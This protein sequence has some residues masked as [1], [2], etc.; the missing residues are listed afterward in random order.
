MDAE[1]PVAAQNVLIVER[2]QPSV[3]EPSPPPVAQR[4][5]PP[6]FDPQHT[7]DLLEE[8][9]RKEILQW[10]KA[11]LKYLQDMRRK[12][13]RAHRG[14][15]KPLILGQNAFV[16]AARGIVWDLRGDKP[17][18]LDFLALTP[19]HIDHAFLLEQLKLMGWPDQQIAG[20]LEHGVSYLADVELQIVLMPPL[21][22]FADGYT[23]FCA[24][25]DELTA[26]GWHKLTKDVMPPFLP[27][28]LI[29]R[30]SAEKPIGWRITSDA[31][32]G[33]TERGDPLFASD[34]SPFFSLNEVS[35]AQAWP[36]EI[37]PF[38]RDLLEFLVAMSPLLAATGWTVMAA[39]EDAR[40]FFNQWR[41]RPEELWK[42]VALFDTP[43]GTPLWV[44][45]LVMSFGLTPA[46][47]VAQRMSDIVHA[48]VAKE[49]DKSDLE[50]IP[51]LRRENPAIDAW[52]K[53]REELSRQLNVVKEVF[54]VY[55]KVEDRKMAFC[56]FM[57]EPLL[58]R[59]FTRD[60]VRMFI[61]LREIEN[62][63][64]YSVHQCRLWYLPVFTD[65]GMLLA[66]GPS[67]LTRLLGVWEDV[68]A[69]V[70]ILYNPGKAQ[71]GTHLTWIG[72]G[73]LLSLTAA[74]IPPKKCLRALARITQAVA[75][76]LNKDGYRRLLGLLE[77][78]V[79][80]NNF[81][82]SL[83][84][85]LWSVLKGDAALVNPNEIAKLTK[86]QVGKLLRWADLL[87]HRSVA[88]A[89]RVVNADRP[90]G[91]AQLLFVASSDAAKEGAE[92][93]GLGAFMHGFCCRFPLTAEHL[94]WLHITALE[95]A[96]FVMDF[97]MVAAIFPKQLKVCP[98]TLF[99]VDA[100]STAHVHTKLKTS[101]PQMEL[102]VRTVRDSDEFGRIGPGCLYLEWVRWEGP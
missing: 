43:D 13:R 6:G 67:T 73:L 15:L 52:M 4:S 94:K 99:E 83:M 96:A 58:A 35:K 33:G 82:R 28:R 86:F 38:L 63:V 89:L 18:P 37:K 11:N 12:G 75:G 59:G 9:A 23:D 17:V 60:Q 68:K 97:F 79:F 101:K 72:A 84:H 88:S 30:G 47:N 5:P 41:L 64:V 8:W 81:S 55:R 25:L 29:P 85:G 26:C 27:V 3:T 57:Q 76:E 53:H 62:I 71:I 10:L 24:D 65:D 77:H 39:S 32:G 74:Y 91:P 61:N 20:F 70:G 7:G 16:E 100:S 45:E 1:V 95:N 66:L 2:C 92:R 14:R 36:K 31:G 102:C 78:F 87:V 22:S 19:S 40:K 54:A 69:K 90:K 56:D 80:L 49:M 21:A 42:V 48:V 44:S 46:S 93:P 51:K 98:R 50:A 34:G